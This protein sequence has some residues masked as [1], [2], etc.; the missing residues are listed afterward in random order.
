MRRGWNIRDYALLFPSNPETAVGGHARYLRMREDLP[1]PE[2]S[3]AMKRRSA[4]MPRRLLV[5]LHDVSP[6][7]ESEIDH[8]RDAL[9]GYLA[10]E[11]MALFVIPNHWD[12]APIKGG[13]PFARRLFSWAE[14]GA[15][16]FVHGWFH[17]DFCRHASTMDG[18]RA[19]YMT[20]REGEFLG[21][22][23]GEALRRMRDGRSLLEDVTGRPV[24]GF[25]A[26]AWLYGQGAME[27][28]RD[29]G[30]TIA[31]DHMRVWNPQT[32]QRLGS[33]PVLTWASRSPARIKASLV[34]AALLPGLLRR[35]PVARIGVHPGDTG[36]PELM[37]SI[38][39]SVRAMLRSHKPARY[40]DL[41]SADS[42][43]A[44]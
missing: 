28:L 36:Q 21:L 33:G 37:L 9:Q 12:A 34:A 16:I 22:S 39:R 23:R 42:P 15:E 30:F 44:Y 40:A 14:R 18:L 29:A 10:T 13:S 11:A 38:M 27:A 25:V 19:R 41:Q 31:E 43:C 20:A 4:I 6:R 26:P 2:E 17:Q 5:S 24:A 32:G 8:L 3:S 35:L 1:E 7:F